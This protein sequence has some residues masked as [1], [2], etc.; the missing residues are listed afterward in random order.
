MRLLDKAQDP[1]R[2]ERARLGGSQ[3]GDDA[4]A[5]IRGWSEEA[6][7]ILDSVPDDHPTRSIGGGV[8]FIDWLATRVV[9]LTVHTLDLAAAVGIDAEPPEAALATTLGVLSD[10]GV[11][12][13]KASEL[14]MAATGRSGLPAGYSLMA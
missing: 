3:L 6:L 14:V 2:E 8:R 5:V 11:A 4:P 12:T 1:A 10:L 9:E 7:A 13:G